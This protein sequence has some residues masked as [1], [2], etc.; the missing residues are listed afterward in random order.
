VIDHKLSW[1]PYT[2]Q[3]IPNLNK[4]SYVIRV[5]KPLLSLECL[6]A[7]YISLLHSLISNVIIFCGRSAHAKITFKIQKRIIRIITN[8][9]NVD[10]CQNLF[11]ELQILQLQLQYIFSLLMLIVKNR[12]CYKTNSDVHT[13]NT[14]FNH[15]LHLPVAN[16]SI[17]QKG[18]WYSGIKLYNRLPPMLKQLFHD[19]PKLKVALKSSLLP[20]P[21]ILLR[22]TTAGIKTDFSCI[23]N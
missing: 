18:G 15:D 4:A 6:K 21:F 17:F 7:V 22:S 20:I 19:I 8:S 23:I 9:H 5:L 16:L 3:M 2:D 1:H 14:R 13:C 10:S 12:D 11:K